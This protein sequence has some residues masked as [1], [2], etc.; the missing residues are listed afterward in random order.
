MTDDR[1]PQPVIFEETQTMSASLSAM[2]AAVAAVALGSAWFGV[3]REGTI[4]RAAPG[5]LTGT[6]AAGGAVGLVAFSRLI[7]KVTPSEA[8]ITFWPFKR[9]RLSAE[10]IADAQPKTFGLFDGGIGFHIGW[11]SLALTATTGMGVVITRPDGR[12][13]LVGTQRPDALLA[14]LAQLRR[15][16]DRW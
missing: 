6:V 12:T 13:I 8:M 14:A 3:I 15:G 11:R 16:T 10:D 1:F 9:I 7:T 2:V 4:A 5:L